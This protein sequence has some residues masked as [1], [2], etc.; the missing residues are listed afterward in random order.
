[1][2]V[3][4]PAW[5]A[6]DTF[7][8]FMKPAVC[9]IAF[10]FALLAGGCSTVAHNVAAPPADR[11]GIDA[12]TIPREQWEPR[13]E[14]TVSTRLRGSRNDVVLTEVRRTPA[15]YQ[16]VRLQGELTTKARPKTQM[17][18]R[19]PN[20]LA[21]RGIG[22]RAVVAFVVDA[23]GYVADPRVIEASDG[24]LARAA[25]EA[26]ASWT[27]FA[28]TLDGVPTSAVLVEEMTFSREDD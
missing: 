18:P 13:Y 11:P 24:R 25:T 27:Y 15:V 2:A 10:A 28:G 9:P 23:N 12:S 7:D 26:I 22:G 6:S 19:Y 5:Q 8:H 4:G 3:R 17:V 21:V 20:D 1:M 16:H 14:V